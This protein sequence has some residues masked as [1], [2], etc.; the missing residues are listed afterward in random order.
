MADIPLDQYCA[1]LEQTNDGSNDDKI[2]TEDPKLI[3]QSMQE[4][5]ERQERK[6]ELEPDAKK[7]KIDSEGGKQFFSL[8]NLPN[9]EK[10]AKTKEEGEL[11]EGEV[12][13][14]EQLQVYYIFI[15]YYFCTGHLEVFPKYLK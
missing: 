6:N 1:Q 3:F 5:K 2:L 4:E 13:D 10:E 8:P 15:L 7:A 14:D 12:L 9:V 11:E